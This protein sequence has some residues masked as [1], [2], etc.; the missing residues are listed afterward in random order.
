[1]SQVDLISVFKAVTETLQEN[2]VNL[3]EADTY[4]HD[5]GDHMVQTFKT[6]TNA[7]ARAKTKTP[8]AQL[9]S[10]SRA[11]SKSTSG[12]A[13]IYAQGLKKA[14]QDFKGKDLT[15]DN[16]GLLI[17]SLMGMGSSAAATTKPGVQYQA[18]SGG[19]D[20]L[21]ELLGG[22]MGQD[23]SQSAPRQQQQSSGDDLLG[24]L[25]GG[26]VGGGQTQSAP[27][28]SQN[29][30]SD[31]LLG[32][33]LGGLLGGQTQQQTPQQSQSSGSGDL[34]GDLLGGLLGGQSQEPAQEA[35]RQ[36]QL[37]RPKTKKQTPQQD[38]SG[39]ILGDLLGGLL[40]GSSSSQQSNQS[41]PEDM[42]GDLLSGKS[43]TSTQKSTQSKG[44]DLG[45]LLSAGLAY[46]AA[47]K[48]GKSSLEAIIAALSKASPLASTPARTQ[49]GALIINTILGMLGGAR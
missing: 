45:S 8:S 44:I 10:A 38:T 18:Q 41:S 16:V 21:T 2:Q 43:S 42:L 27:Q 4:N 49:S 13:Q 28:Q 7:A 39:D 1:M 9:A 30:G 46:Y 37:S 25:L 19:G 6:I 32:D 5:H 24:D 48:G 22:L 47:K 15:S 40:G 34:L 35:Q 36:G 31:D 12:S 3:N 11:L 14:S 17:N 26:L 20:L 29:Q 33:L 23:S